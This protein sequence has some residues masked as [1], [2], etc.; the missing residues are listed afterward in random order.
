MFWVQWALQI[1]QYRFKSMFVLLSKIIKVHTV[2]DDADD[3]DEW[4]RIEQYWTLINWNDSISGAYMI[5]KPRWFSIHCYNFGHWYEHSNDETLLQQ[6]LC[7]FLW[8]SIGIVGGRF[9]IKVYIYAIIYAGNS[10]K[11]SQIMC[12]LPI[13]LILDKAL[14]DLNHGWLKDQRVKEMVQ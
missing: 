4:L 1:F 5:L 6:Q 2:V 8:P 13:K 9:Q 11:W 3:D 14:T 12:Q 10:S 7:W